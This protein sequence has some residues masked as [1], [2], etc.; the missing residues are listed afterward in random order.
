MFPAHVIFFAAITVINLIAITI[1]SISSIGNGL[2][3]HMG[4]Q[5]CERAS[6]GELALLCNG[7]IATANIHIT[8][9]AFLLLPVQLWLL[10]SHVDWKLGVHLSVTQQLGV[11]SGMWLV[12]YIHSD[13]VARFLGFTMFATAVQK[14]FAELRLSRR[15]DSDEEAAAMTRYE[16]NTWN[17][18]LIVWFVGLSSGLFGGLYAAGG[19]PLMYFVTQINLEKNTCRGTV[20]FLYLV[21]N[22][23]RIVF[24]FFLRHDSAVSL[25][26]PTFL[27][28]IGALTGSS[29]LGLGIGNCVSDQIDQKCFRYMILA[30][31]SLGSILLGT[32]GFG[33]ETSVWI[34][35]C[36]GILILCYYVS[37]YEVPH[38]SRR[39]SQN[40]HTNMVV[41]TG[42]TRRRNQPVRF[43]END[44]ELP[45]K[46][47][48]ERSSSMQNAHVVYTPLSNN[49]DADMSDI[50]DVA[51]IED[52][53]LSFAFA[54]SNI[55]IGLVSAL[56]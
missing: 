47:A 45:V 31:L 2:L 51:E 35:T 16:F 54:E 32:T 55:D 56:V 21:E 38:Q 26:N 44:L 25:T 37:T 10:Y 4:W 53:D 5:V 23:G 29:L 6:S 1:Y 3:Y 30:V 20:A 41:C 11:F 15:S 28:T 24:I 13:W 27:Y 50:T 49:S 42:S 52:A 18:Y 8:V 40:E 17:D 34:V 43:S 19:P 33:L 22:L 14:S 9:A 36:F 12:F 39:V 7:D 46:L 48:P